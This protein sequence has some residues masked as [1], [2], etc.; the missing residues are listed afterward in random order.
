MV[1]AAARVGLCCLVLAS[2]AAAARAEGAPQVTS[3]IACSEDADCPRHSDCWFAW[4]PGCGCDEG[5]GRCDPNPKPCGRADDCFGRE[6]CSS[7]GRCVEPGPGRRGDACNFDGECPDWTLCLG[8][9]CVNDC[10]VDS[11][12]EAGRC[13]GTRC[14]GCDRDTDCPG[15]SI[16]RD[17]DCQAVRCVADAECRAREVCRAGGCVP[18]ECR[19][20]RDCRGCELCSSENACVG[21]CREG[22]ECRLLIDP[23][24]DGRL[25]VHGCV[26]A[27][28][29]CRT[30]LDCAGRP[31]LGGRCIDLDLD[32]FLNRLRAGARGD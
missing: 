14:V 12:C 23:D 6:I 15:G 27:D 24:P 20:S 13:Q 22:E 8:G 3:E 30:R 25:L 5:R 2:L 32:R 17:G 11:D 16:C 9:A 21:L 4:W 28:A 18:V 7:E 26:D 29:S 1:R 19:D 10:V 31:C